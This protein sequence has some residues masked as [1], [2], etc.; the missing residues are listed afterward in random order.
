MEVAALT[1]PFS[2]PVRHRKDGAGLERK[3]LD[4]PT[5]GGPSSG[6]IL[7]APASS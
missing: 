5:E 3:A 7:K 2:R 1:R 4:A 6:Y